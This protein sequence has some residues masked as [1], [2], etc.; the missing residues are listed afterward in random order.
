MKTL[1]FAS[2]PM[3]GPPPLPPGQDPCFPNV[4]IPINQYIGLLV[5][6]AILYGTYK[7]MDNY[8]ENKK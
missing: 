1:L 8:L 4:C 5:M 7:L 6:V 2:P 3:G